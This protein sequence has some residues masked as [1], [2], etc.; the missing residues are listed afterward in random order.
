[1]WWEWHMHMCMIWKNNPSEIWTE[2]LHHC[3]LFLIFKHVSTFFM[4]FFPFL[5][6]T[7]EMQ[8]QHNKYQLESMKRRVERKYKSQSRWKYFQGH[9][10]PTEFGILFISLLPLPPHIQTYRITKLSSNLIWCVWSWETLVELWIE[11]HPIAIPWIWMI[12]RWWDD[13]WVCHGV[14]SLCLQSMLR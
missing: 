10:H 2:N 4:I 9:F 5:L 6:H 14:V 7:Y 8:I 13:E 11:H 1:M 12:V 3:K